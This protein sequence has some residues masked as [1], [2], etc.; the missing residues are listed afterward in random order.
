MSTTFL[1]SVGAVLTNGL[2]AVVEI[3]GIGEGKIKLVY[4]PEIGAAPDNAS[5]EVIKLRSAI[6]RPLIITGTPEEVE[7]AF[8]QK[9]G[10][11][12]RAVTR[13]LSALD[14]IERLSVAALAAAR[15]PKSAPSPAPTGGSR[16][17]NVEDS[18]Q[19][20][21]VVQVEQA[22]AATASN[23]MSAEHF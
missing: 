11:S 23:P 14:E 22:T 21:S 9:I 20:A 15:S 18:S 13:G 16:T 4:S 12:A 8:V 10:E 3:N 6:S 2:K 1:Q 17:P 5:D 7:T 19:G